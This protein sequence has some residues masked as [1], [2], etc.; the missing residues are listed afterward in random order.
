MSNIFVFIGILTCCILIW[1]A[2][3][4]IVDNGDIVSVDHGHIT[5]NVTMLRTP[6]GI[7][8]TPKTE[9]TQKKYLIYIT[10]HMS[11]EHKSFFKQCWPGILSQ[12]L[13]DD[14]D[15]RIFTT[16]SPPWLYNIFNNNVI[17]SKYSNPGY[18]AGANLA[19]REM[20]KHQW[21]EGYEWVIRVNP[22]VIIR[23]DKWIL[24]TL[25]NTNID[26]IFADCIDK[27]CTTSHCVQNHPHADFFALRTSALKKMSFAN[28]QK[29]AE[30][31]FFE[32]TRPII[33]GGKDAWL[34]D[35]GPHTGEC[36]V[37][38]THSPVIHEHSYLQSCKGADDE[39]VDNTKEQKQ[40][41]IPTEHVYDSKRHSYDKIHELLH[42]IQR[43]ACSNVHV[44]KGENAK[45]PDVHICLDNIS[46]PCVVY[47]FGIAN[48]WIFDDFMISKGCHVYSF[49]P[50][51]EIG[52]HKRHE[53]HLFEPIGIGSKSGK[54]RGVSTLYGGK[55]KYD[56]LSLDDIMKRYNHV[57][58]DMIRMDTEYA[59]WDVLQQWLAADMF[60]KFDQLLLEIH[61]WPKSNHPNH[62]QLHSEILHSIPMTLFHEARNKWDGTR[63]TGDMT[64]VYEVGFIKKSQVS[65]ASSND[66]V[67]GPEPSKLE[68]KSPVSQRTNVIFFH[69]K[70]VKWQEEAMRHIHIND[71]DV[72]IV[73]ITKDKNTHTYKDYVKTVYTSEL[74]ADTKTILNLWGN[75]AIL[76][77]SMM[78]FYYIESYLRLNGIE[79]TFHVESD[80]S[81]RGK[82]SDI[83]PIILRKKW[84]LAATQLC[85]GMMTASVMY[86]R[87]HSDMRDMIDEAEKWFKLPHEK[88]FIYDK[89]KKYPGWASSEMSFLGYYHYNFPEKMF[90]LPIL[91]FG[92]Y[93]D[94]DFPYLFDPATYHQW[95]R[96]LKRE[97]HHIVQ[98]ALSSGQV[99][100]DKSK[101][102]VSFKGR[103]FPLFNVH[104]DNKKLHEKK[105]LIAD[106]TPKTTIQSNSLGQKETF[107][108][109]GVTH[110]ST[111]HK[112]KAMQR[113]WI[114]KLK[115]FAWYSTEPDSD[116]NPHVVPWPGGN[117][118]SKITYRSLLVF[119]HV[120]ENYPGYDW[121]VRQFDDTYVF[122]ERLEKIVTNMDPNKG[123]V[124]GRNCW[125]GNIRFVCGGPPWVISRGALD[126]WFKGNE[127]PDT[128]LQK[129][130]GVAEDV[131]ISDAMYKTGKVT[132]Y[133][134]TGFHAQSLKHAEVALTAREVIQGKMAAEDRK[135]KRCQWKPCV[136]TPNDLGVIALHYVPVKDAELIWKEDVSSMKNTRVEQFDRPG[137]KT[138]N[139]KLD[140]RSKE[141]QPEEFRHLKHIRIDMP[142]VFNLHMNTRGLDSATINKQCQYMLINL[143]EMTDFP[144]QK[145]ISS[146]DIF[147]HAADKQKN[148]VSNC[149][150]DFSDQITVYYYADN[151]KKQI[152]HKYKS[153][154]ETPQRDYTL[155]L[156]LE[157]DHLLKYDFILDWSK[158]NYLLEI[159]GLADEGFVRTCVQYEICNSKKYIV[160]ITKRQPLPKNIFK[161]MLSEDSV[162]R[163]KTHN[164]FRIHSQDGEHYFI[165]LNQPYCA[166]TILT[167]T[168]RKQW[169]KTHLFKENLG[170]FGVQETAANNYILNKGQADWDT[171]HIGLVPVFQNGELGGKIHHMPNKYCANPKTPFGKFS[172]PFF[173][174]LQ[175]LKISPTTT[176]TYHSSKWEQLWI[177]NIEKWQRHQICEVLAGQK[178][179][180]SSFMKD[181][182][183]ATTDTD[184]CLI[185]D[186]VHQVWYNTK[187]GQATLQKPSSVTSISSLRKIS[188][189][190]DL[191]WSYFE[192]SDGTREYIE[193]LVSHLRHPLARCL[194]G[195]TFLI[196]R[197]YVLPGNPGSSKTFLF[198]AGASHWSQGAGG[199][200]L[201]YFTS[202][203]KRYGFDWSHIE[204]W[205][206]GTTVAKFESTVPQEWRSKT[207]FHQDWISTS[208]NKQPFV[209]DVIQSTASKEDY[210]VFKLD[211]DSKSVETA[212]VDYLLTHIEAL[213]YI[214]EFVWEQH[215]DNYLMAGN[216]GNTQDMSKSIADSYQYFLKL[217]KLGVRAHS[218][219]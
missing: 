121:Y 61:M 202:V 184:W 115:S 25:D 197:S 178:E 4:H 20:V 65:G 155:F 74:D 147:I 110:P 148:I 54:H 113:T 59:E 44:I 49:D 194:F 195:D 127:N 87:K 174:G 183:S 96:G 67:P 167:D 71:P 188:P 85:V 29:C 179:Y 106:S 6:I 90:S 82:F 126:A 132:F 186:S 217:R 182:C 172:E 112:A 36:R 168:R 1:S 52:K 88:V 26:G 151:D 118:Y 130:W 3:R 114:T 173:Q 138:P 53:N 81:I 58:V 134:S 156:Y 51:M 80:N 27:G 154:W 137:E 5:R 101:W 157:H 91:P 98:Q 215:V 21:Y 211:I 50:S 219:V 164:M 189:K 196:D 128:M 205:E 38:G 213:E 191:I 40:T 152:T 198:D 159:N 208:P 10:T 149:L 165:G 210:V 160:G 89:T 187:N 99:K 103:Q 163:D 73:Y 79:N 12:K 46:P 162:T 204:G 212:I 105:Y 111:I 122:P 123:I 66:I 37:R 19:M 70:Y 166:V 68:N 104:V 108:Y 131:Y 55:T 56:V 193:P 39:Q 15:I 125:L 129:K 41:R 97:T 42:S 142:L 119:K 175:K 8:K 139:V 35:S 84:P 14:S 93:S 169:T 60:S 47:S 86:I 161:N 7:E 145:Y 64:R 170:H 207:Y 185:D 150:R 24:K 209:P 28:I 63:L 171:Y 133:H 201:S 62:G 143:K 181:T 78:R 141:S 23:D 107:F 102:S 92:K 32:E 48:N 18:Q 116:L 16:E 13:F 218:W 9:K 180:I 124:V 117:E 94:L 17:V 45:E 11:E 77:T 146:I 2:R 34:I 100:L 203:W 216:W 200:S 83:L 144:R 140:N 158:D 177:E 206:G 33:N 30:C 43:D 31:I 176:K 57:H 153:G 69:D 109:F 120:W 192:L 199:P 136:N 22:D 135:W 75:S 214:D 76:T 95:S 190:D 72:Q